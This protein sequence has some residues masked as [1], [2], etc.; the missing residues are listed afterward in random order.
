MCLDREP[1]V[2]NMALQML[3][4][5]S[6]LPVCVRRCCL[7]TPIEANVLLHLLHLYGLSPLEIKQCFNKMLNPLPDDNISDTGPN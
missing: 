7:A 5:Y 2:V 6:L 4:R 3:H 1:F